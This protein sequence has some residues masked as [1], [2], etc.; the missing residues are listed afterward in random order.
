MFKDFKDFK[1]SS[2]GN[3]AVNTLPNQ[4]SNVHET[5]QILIL[6]QC[7]SEVEKLKH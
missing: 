7:T 2:Y 5:E 6:E 3:Y 1:L 4:V